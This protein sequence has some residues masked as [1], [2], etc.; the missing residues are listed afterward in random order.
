MGSEDDL[1]VI[2]F[3]VSTALDAAAPVVVIAFVDCGLVDVAAVLIGCGVSYV[4][5]GFVAAP[6]PVLGFVGDCFVAVPVLCIDLVL[7][8]VELLLLELVP[9]FISLGVSPVGEGVVGV[10][11]LGNDCVGSFFK[12]LF[13][14]VLVLVPIG[15]GVSLFDSLVISS[16]FEVAAVDLDTT[17]EVVLSP[18]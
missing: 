3:G 10:A 7:W 14:D 8:I 6:A 16:V 4:E 2:G 1:L 18:I 9:L 12:E 17:N 15:L 11:K 13:E 5:N